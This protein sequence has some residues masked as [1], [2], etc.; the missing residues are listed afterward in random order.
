[1]VT[2]LNIINNDQTRSNV[3]SAIRRLLIGSVTMATLL[4]GAIKAQAG[5]LPDPAAPLPDL[6]FSRHTNDQ[7]RKSVV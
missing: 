5:G 6:D 4:T 7:D 1:M 3:K 2:S